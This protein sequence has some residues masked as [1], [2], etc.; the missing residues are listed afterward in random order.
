MRPRRTAAWGSALLLLVF[1]PAIAR[2][3]DDGIS[4]SDHRERRF[5]K[6]QEAPR[7][8]RDLVEAGRKAREIQS[9]RESRGQNAESQPPKDGQASEHP[10]ARE[11]QAV[12]RSNS[13]STVARIGN[14]LGR[15]IVNILTGWVEFP[16]QIVKRT[17]SDGIGAGLTLGILEGVGMTVVRTLGGAV[18][19]V[20]FLAPLPG[21]YDPLL[22]PP[23]VFH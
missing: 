23:L 20:T 3:E 13:E 7:P 15:G 18:E 4:P 14:K 22:E 8:P 10:Q 9:D 6:Q 17:K 2:A 11:R 1:L 12:E 5:L 19:V 16:V 21:N